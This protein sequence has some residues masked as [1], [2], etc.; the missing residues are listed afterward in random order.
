MEKEEKYITKDLYQVTGYLQ[1]GED[2]QLHTFV[3]WAT[4]FTTA[5]KKVKAKTK[6]SLEI[7]S[8]SLMGAF[9]NLD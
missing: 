4:S 9:V 3:V 1:V 7:L 5:E 6:D 8:I 2:K